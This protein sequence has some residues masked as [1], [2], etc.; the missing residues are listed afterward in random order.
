M[1]IKR[2]KKGI[3]RVNRDNWDNWKRSEGGKRWRPPQLPQ[4]SK[5]DWSL[6][7]IKR[8]RS[9]QAMKNKASRELAAL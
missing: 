5:R 8:E 1:L 2:R 3:G 4:S 9:L 6:T 7:G